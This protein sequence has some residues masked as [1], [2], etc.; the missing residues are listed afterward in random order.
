[1]KT[2]VREVREDEPVT[3]LQNT[4]PMM[5]TSTINMHN[6]NYS[7]IFDTSIAVCIF[8]SNIYYYKLMLIVVLRY[9]SI[10]TTRLP[11]R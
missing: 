11:S 8:L 7:L 9:Q 3:S 10:S 5:Q 4:N 2:K 6:R 1:M